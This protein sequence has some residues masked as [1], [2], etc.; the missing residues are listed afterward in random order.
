MTGAQARVLVT[1][2]VAGFPFPR[3]PEATVVL[4]VEQFAKLADA[5][6]ARAAVELL[7]ANEERFPSFATV[8]R[9]YRPQATRNADARARTHGLAEPPPCP[10]NARR[11]RA[12]LERLTGAIDARAS[13]AG[14]GDDEERPA[15]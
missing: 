2:L 3:V 8:L 6:A 5:D 7:I 13:S 11:A 1:A 9:E 4:Y 15:A 12:L 10:D 14:P